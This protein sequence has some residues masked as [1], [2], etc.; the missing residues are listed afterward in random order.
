MSNQRHR[1]DGGSG[2]NSFTNVVVERPLALNSELSKGNP[3]KQL[4]QMKYVIDTY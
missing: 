1:L 4:Q 3:I 2:A